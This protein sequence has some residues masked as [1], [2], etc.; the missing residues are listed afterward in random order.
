MFGLKK[1]GPSQPTGPFEHAFGCKV[2]V[3]DPG[4]Q[5]EWQEI[6]NGLWRRICQCYAED[7]YEPPVDTRPRL[8][9]WD[10]ATFHHLGGCEHRDVSDPTI[11][12]AILRVQ[13]RE[14]YWRVDCAS[15][16]GC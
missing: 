12:K 11:N 8:D 1:K 2:V 5:P 3:A 14:G 10:P 7:R 16:D 15:C 13:P 4:F 9:P 6:E